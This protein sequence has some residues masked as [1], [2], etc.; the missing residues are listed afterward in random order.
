MSA[1]KRANFVAPFTATTTTTTTTTTHKV[2]RT[3]GDV[4]ASYESILS[5]LATVTEFAE[6]GLSKPGCWAYPDVSRSAATLHRSALLSCAGNAVA[7]ALRPTPT[8]PV[9]NRSDRC[10]RWAARGERLR[11]RSLGRVW[12]PSKQFGAAE[13]APDF[14]LRRLAP[15]AIARYATR[16][17]TSQEARPLGWSYEGLLE[18]WIHSIRPMSAKVTATLPSLPFGTATTL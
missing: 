6:A 2:Y 9:P 15:R 1:T 3:S 12:P 7:Y 16:L 4:R 10:S 11:I 18:P 8:P 5:N 17:E 13:V 14:G